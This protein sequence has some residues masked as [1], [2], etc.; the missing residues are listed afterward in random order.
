MSEDFEKDIKEL[1]AAGIKG[2]KANVEGNEGVLDEKSF[3]A[4]EILNKCI[5]EIGKRLPKDGDNSLA[6]LSNEELS[7]DFE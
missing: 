4:L 3:R 2:L 5:T 7:S 6:S 1:I